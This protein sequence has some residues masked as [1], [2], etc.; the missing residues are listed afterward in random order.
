ML[1]APERGRQAPFCSATRA[2]ECV[3]WSR[4]ALPSSVR[5][6]RSSKARSLGR[7]PR[8]YFFNCVL[9]C[10]SASAMGC[11]ASR[12]YCAW[13]SWWGT[14]DRTAATAVR[15]VSCPAEMMPRMGSDQAWR[16]GRTS[17]KSAVALRAAQEGAGQQDLAREALTD[18]P[19][20]FM[21]DIG[22]HPTSGCTRHRAASHQWRGRRDLGWQ[23]AR[24][25]A[26]GRPVAA[27]PVPRSGGPVAVDQ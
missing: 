24:A 27:P 25:G 8:T 12:R 10:R 19:Q 18:D 13:P 2:M 14:S 1:E 11:A 7:T 4:G 20:D 15:M 5:A 17:L 3:I 22:L 16:V 21:P 26:P 9:A 23:G 6:L